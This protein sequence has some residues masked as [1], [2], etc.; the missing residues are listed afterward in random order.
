M[1]L[2]YTWCASAAWSVKNVRDTKM[3][4]DCDDGDNLVLVRLKGMGSA[5]AMT[6]AWAG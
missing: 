4:I 6:F 3:L 2:G 1:Y 5:E